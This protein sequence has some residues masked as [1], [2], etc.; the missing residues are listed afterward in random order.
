[1]AKVS[2]LWRIARSARDLLQNNEH[3]S[4]AKR[5]KFSQ[6][7]AVRRDK[8]KSSGA[9]KEGYRFMMRK[10]G[11]SEE[12]LKARF[13]R[14]RGMGITD[15]NFDK[16]RA[17]GLYMMEDE[18]AR[19]TLGKLKKYAE[20]EDDLRWDFRL[21]DLGKKTYDD[22]SDKI[23]TLNSL[24]SE[25]MTPEAKRDIAMQA[26]YLDPENMSD[27]ETDALAMD[28]EFTRWIL[29][30]GYNEYVKYHFHDKSI[31][32]RTEFL[33]AHERKMLLPMLN[34]DES[35]AILDDKLLTYERLKDH[36]GR[37]MVSIGS[38]KDYFRF[39]KFFENNEA[40]VIKPRF[41]LQGK[42]VKLV[43]RPEK[44]DMFRTFLKLVDDY[45]R[46]LME[47]YIDAAEEL[48]ALN[49]DSVNTV[50]VIAY[51]DGEKTSVRSASIRIGRT[52]SFVDNAGAG[53][54]T[55]AIDRETGMID[56]D[57]CDENGYRYKSHPDTGIVFNGYQL[58][59]WDKA[60]ETIHAVS[61]RI[62][63]ASYVGW[64]LACTSDHEWA[65]VEA[66]GKT[67]FF[68][69]QAPH[70]RGRRA[71][72]LET[73]GADPR[74]ELYNE[75]ALNM[76]KKLK[77]ESNIPVKETMKN[78]VRCESLGLDGRY[79]KAFRAW[80]LTDEECVELKDAIEERDAYAKSREE[81]VAKLISKKYGLDAEDVRRKY[82]IALESGYKEYWFLADGIFMLTDEE[83]KAQKHLRVSEAEDDWEK[84]RK[85]SFAKIRKQ[86]IKDNQWSRAKYSLEQLKALNNC[87][88]AADEF[89]VFRIWDRD[90]GE[91][92]RFLTARIKHKAW[93]KNASTYEDS[94]KLRNKLRFSEE[95][96]EFVN[97]TVFS[98]RD[99]SYEAFEEK[100]KGLD[101]IIYKPEEGDKGIGMEK[102]RVNESAEG[103]RKAYD[104]LCSLEPGVVEEFLYQHPDIAAFYPDAVNTMR[105][106]TALS[107]GEARVVMA[108][109][110]TGRYGSTDN[111]SQGGV[112][113]G[114]NAETG[115]IE[116]DGADY[117][118]ER[119]TEH[120]VTGKTFKGSAIPE[121]EKVVHSCCE[122][123]KRCPDIPLIGWDAAVLSDGR[124]VLIEGNQSFGTKSIQTPYS[125]DDTGLRERF[126]EFLQL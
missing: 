124:A 82:R 119:Y 48:R 61:G 35:I 47:G 17:Y 29:R 73:I 55:A 8:K 102:I 101:Y 34:T 20:L 113:A 40:A 30:F 99:L 96:G 5:I 18:Q 31:P 86:I 67:G 41:D 43:R 118:G 71:E 121:W 104:H 65:V 28:M 68:G 117:N 6:Q 54:I 64:D 60:L 114:I 75:I 115:I 112:S 45:R 21:I 103:N 95:F 70:D 123:A 33:S 51:H 14:Y 27:E 93:L 66:N 79:F 9:R 19:Q 88:C 53:G 56:S 42:G 22:V 16:F 80:E 120:P 89:I 85:K 72:F 39:K 106:I 107:D 57:G 26:G 116:T 74:G 91:A 77:E 76:A 49:P 46:F 105:V 36:Y 23:G 63:G 110:R 58:P 10:T 81:D 38:E 37:E 100:I 44:S 24:K 111:W 84:E 52:G 11:L 92:R 78:L 94:L 126:E 98:N 122:A 3:A 15:L 50:R 2:L 62:E 32:E 125:L 1:M 83:I 69:A 25:L 90:P 12:E 13:E 7:Q 59:A 97:R 108:I 4:T 87:G 109:L